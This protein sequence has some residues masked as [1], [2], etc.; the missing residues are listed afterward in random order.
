MTLF[1]RAF[2]RQTS[3]IIDRLDDQDERITALERAVLLLTVA[4]GKQDV[5]K[6]ETP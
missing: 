1:R 3:L 4:M 6:G 5:T 2:N